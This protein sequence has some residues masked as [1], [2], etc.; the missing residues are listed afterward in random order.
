[1]KP[2][3]PKAKAPD[4]SGAEHLTNAD[5]GSNNNGKMQFVQMNPMNSKYKDAQQTN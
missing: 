5:A 2:E 4:R 3:Q 1:M